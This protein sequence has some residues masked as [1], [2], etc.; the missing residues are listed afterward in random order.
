MSNYVTDPS[1]LALPVYPKTDR[2]PVPFGEDPSKWVAAIDWNAFGAALEDIRLF[3][4][5][6]KLSATGLDTTGLTAGDVGRLNG[7]NTIAKANAAALA[8]SHVYGINDG[9]VGAMVVSGIVLANFVV[10]LSLLPDDTAYLASGVNAG[11]LTNVIPV[12]GCAAAIGRIQ[13]ASAY[14]GMQKALIIL[15]VKT[16]FQL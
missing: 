9:V 14:A 8:T 15:Q 7:T 12:S 5:A 6:A 11:K 3:L 1:G 2:D 4:R 13:D 16:I 10:G